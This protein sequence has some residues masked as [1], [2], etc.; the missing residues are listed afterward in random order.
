MGK[1]GMDIYD[2]VGAAL[3]LGGMIYVKVYYFESIK[4]LL[5]G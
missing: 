1:R 5:F 4:A 2:I 3:V